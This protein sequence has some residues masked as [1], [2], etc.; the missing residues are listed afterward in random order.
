MAWYD[1]LPPVYAFKKGKE[2]L[3]DLKDEAA[4]AT[5][6]TDTSMSE[7]DRAAM[8]DA[9]GRFAEAENAPAYTPEQI[10]A[11]PIAV[12][13]MQAATID[14]AAGQQIR[15][16]QMEYLDALQAAAEGRAPSVAEAQMGRAL[17]A[18]NDHSLG[19]AASA[20]GH[21]RSFLTREA[22]IQ[23]GNQSQQ[24]AFD[25]ALLRAQEQA[26][27]RAQQ[28]AAL[29]GVRATDTTLATN[30]ANLNQGAAQTNVGLRQRTG[31]VNET[32]RLGAAQSNQTAGLTAA[33]LEQQRLAGLRGDQ[34]TALGGAAGR[35]DA[36]TAS[37]QADKDRKTKVLAAGAQTLGTLGTMIA[38]D[39]RV[40]DGVRPTT[41]A[42]QDGLLNAMRSVAYE[43]KPGE[44][45]PGERAGVLA[46]DLEK[47]KLG[48]SFVSEDERGVEHVDAPGLMLAM[49]GILAR[50]MREERA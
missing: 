8:M 16:Q 25:T 4:D 27:A 45:P 47:S 23:G 22:M 5:S 24:A 48:K 36:I 44:G 32:N 28:G 18:A 2:L 33:E 14:D 20:S 42:E 1:Y 21:D 41:E 17:K 11:N 15:G 34:M 7:A 13:Q 31:E 30:Q 40:K 12:E 9:Y 50:K 10:A 19:M 46:Q 29:E 26:Q 6:A 37:H 43:Y 39:E 3:G 35:G 38:S 49:A